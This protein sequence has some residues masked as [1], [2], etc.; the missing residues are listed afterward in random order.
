MVFGNIRIHE[1]GAFAAFQSLNLRSVLCL[2][3]SDLCHLPSD[4]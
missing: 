1:P 2:L 3:S 4:I